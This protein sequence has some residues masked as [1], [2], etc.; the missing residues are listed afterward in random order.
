MNYGKIFSPSAKILR[1]LVWYKN[2]HAKI[3]PKLGHQS[4]LLT[5]FDMHQL[6]I[7]LHHGGKRVNYWGRGAQHDHTMLIER[8]NSVYGCL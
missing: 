5:R 6:Q 3:V 8:A 7:R 2:T 4:C 1:N